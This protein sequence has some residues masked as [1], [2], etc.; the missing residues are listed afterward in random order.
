M[1]DEP[2]GDFELICD[3]RTSLAFLPTDE[4]PASGGGVERSCP[5]ELARHTMHGAIKQQRFKVMRIST[6]KRGQETI[7][8]MWRGI[9]EDGR[10]AR[11]ERPFIDR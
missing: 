11:Q 1:N 4:S 5:Y 9:L 10:P 2:L 6:W 3:S 7:N 8:D